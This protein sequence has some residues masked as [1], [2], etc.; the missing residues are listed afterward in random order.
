MA[1][2]DALWGVRQH[3]ALSCPITN[4]HHHNDFAFL[5]LLIFHM[6]FVTSVIFQTQQSLQDK[7]FQ[8][9]ATHAR[10][11]AYAVDGNNKH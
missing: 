1:L 4:L 10:G 9:R 8:L 11:T 6:D 2:H 7:H 3:V 5:C